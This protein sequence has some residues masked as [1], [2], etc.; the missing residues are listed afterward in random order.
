MKMNRT[1]KLKRYCE[2]RKKY[3]VAER[4]LGI[5]A[6]MMSYLL[7]HDIDRIVARIDALPLDEKPRRSTAA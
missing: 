3:H 7:K 2:G 1:E 5:P 4:D 6:G